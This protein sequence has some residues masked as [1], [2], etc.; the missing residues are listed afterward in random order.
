MEIDTQIEHFFELEEKY[1]FFEKTDDT[2][3][4]Y[5][6]IVRYQI[7]Q[8]LFRDFNKTMPQS[9]NLTQKIKSIFPYIRTFAD[10]LFSQKKYLFF[11]ASRYKVNGKHLDYIS[12]PYLDKLQKDSFIIESY[13]TIHPHYWQPLNITRFLK[14][15]NKT[16]EIADLLKKEFGSD[17]NLNH[18]IEL[19]IKKYKF[20]LLMYTL[21]IKIIKP[22][23]IFLVQNGIQKSLFQACHTLHIP[24][25]ELQHGN[26]N[27]TNIA[28][29]YPDNINPELIQNTLPS[30][31]FTFGDSW[32]KKIFFPTKIYPV[33]T[34]LNIPSKNH[35]QALPKNNG[36]V[37]IGS[38]RYHEI[39]LPLIQKIAAFFSTT[40]MVYKLHPNQ[41]NELNKI[42]TQL[43]MYKNIE[44]IMDQKIISELINENN[45]FILV[46][47]TI[48]YEVL[49]VQ[50]NV[51]VYKIADYKMIDDVLEYC[52]LFESSDKLIEIIASIQ[53]SQTLYSA[54]KLPEFFKPFNW[55][56]AQAALQKVESI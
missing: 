55:E 3:L 33:G 36:I 7:F 38:F 54:K 21:L 49:N 18:H 41:K 31:I 46:Q 19:L 42:K 24:I 35:N 16:Y 48:A 27:K 25:V 37:F 56:I 47:S 9:R 44:I 30:A 2:N 1:A 29:S 5:W 4:R 50:K 13:D 40:P 20:D 28:Y 34:T 22:R 14:S 10:A 43:A 17:L 45:I 51:C 52:H 32:T 23:L 11:T 15:S 26:I 6:D 8:L 53:N 12:S 39:L